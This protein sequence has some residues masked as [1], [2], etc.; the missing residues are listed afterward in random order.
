M[1]VKYFSRVKHNLPRKKK[2]N[3]KWNMM[4]GEMLD[5]WNWFFKVAEAAS[6][7]RWYTCKETLEL[8]TIFGKYECVVNGLDS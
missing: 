8:K 4:N 7:S 5:G 3:F 1:Q 2:K 6:S